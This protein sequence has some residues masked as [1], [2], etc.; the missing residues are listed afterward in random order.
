[1]SENTNITFKNNSTKNNV[2]I[3]I[4]DDIESVTSSHKLLSDDEEEYVPS[5]Q[6]LNTSYFRQT[7]LDNMMPSFG[8]EHFSQRA[9]WLRAAILGLNDGLVSTSSTMLGVGGG[10]DESNAMFL[11]GVAAL[12]AGSLAMACGEFV[13]VSSQKDAEKAD[14]E[15]EREEHLKG[16][17]HRQKEFEELRDIYIEKGLTPQLATEVAQQLTTD[18]IDDVVKIHARDELGININELANPIQ[19]SIVSAFTFFSGG[20]LPFLSCSFIDDYLTRLFVLFSVSVCLLMT[21]GAIGAH[22]GG[23]PIIKASLRVLI[24]GIIAMLGSFSVGKMFN[25]SVP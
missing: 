6:I 2:D 5:H 11:A 3:D 12:V 9:P 23:A 22:L 21:F 8:H 16:P 25:V 1:M 19:A 7:T 18:N 13:S 24:G 4:D 17:L 10:S 20:I 14:L 15:K